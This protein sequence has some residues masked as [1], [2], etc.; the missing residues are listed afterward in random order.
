M[1]DHEHYILKQPMDSIDDHEYFT[2]DIAEPVPLFPPTGEAF[3][4][5]PMTPCPKV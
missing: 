3:G 1:D 5:D 2:I 4:I